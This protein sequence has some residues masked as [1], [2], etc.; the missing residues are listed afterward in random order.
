M[1]TNAV[2]S[3]P[4]IMVVEDDP[5]V[6]RQIAFALEHEGYAVTTATAGDDALRQLMLDRPDLLVTDVMMP[7]LDGY[8][9]VDQL[10][11]DEKLCDLPV[12]MVTARTAD[13]DI[14]KGFSSG[15]D[16]YIEKPFKPS[17]LVAFVRRFVGPAKPDTQP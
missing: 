17:E 11:R 3:V 9:L 14:S 8:D 13:E 15:I 2:Q 4:K 6:L 1:D 7:G 5:H 12:I 16:I 10:R